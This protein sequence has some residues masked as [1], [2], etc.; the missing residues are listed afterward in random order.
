MGA[1]YCGRDVCRF[2]DGSEFIGNII[3]LQGWQYPICITDEGEI[4][5]DNY[6]GAW[7]EQQQ[8]QQFQQ[9]YAIEAAKCAA[10]EQNYSYTEEVLP[11]GVLKLTIDI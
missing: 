1:I 3:Q 10:E 2:Y 11:T 9:M 8:L 4:K 5:Y 7:G 6:E